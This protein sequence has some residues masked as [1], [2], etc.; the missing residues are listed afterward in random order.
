[1]T[2]VV[3]ENVLS[4]D[5]VEFDEEFQEYIQKIE[6]FKKESSNRPSVDLVVCLGGDGTL[7]H[8]SSL[9]QVNSMSMF[10]I[11]SNLTF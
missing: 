9:F 10:I 7:I 6:P 8:V 1:M 4:E 3:E 2:I 11:L 5:A